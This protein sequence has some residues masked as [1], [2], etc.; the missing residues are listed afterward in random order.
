MGAWAFGASASWFLP[1]VTCLFAFFLGVDGLDEPRPWNFLLAP[2]CAAAAS[3]ISVTV[4]V[5]SAAIYVV[6]DS[7]PSVDR[8]LSHP[9]IS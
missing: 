3:I 8:G 1:F 2:P 7:R 5:L 6:F 9:S 4:W